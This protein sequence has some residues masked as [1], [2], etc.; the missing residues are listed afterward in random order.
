MSALKYA[1]P[2]TH[3]GLSVCL[4]VRVSRIRHCMCARPQTGVSMRAC[5]VH[6]VVRVSV[7]VCAPAQVHL[8]SF[9]RVCTSEHVFVWLSVWFVN[10]RHARQWRSLAC[11]LVFK[12]RLFECLLWNVETPL[13]VLY[14]AHTSRRE[15]EIRLSVKPV[16]Q[17]QQDVCN[18]DTLKCSVSSRDVK[19]ES[20]NQS[21]D[22]LPL[23][24]VFYVDAVVSV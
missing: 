9:Q 16:Y 7:L 12:L 20:S 1:H 14:R 22:F 15:V 11:Q 4:F 24:W 19:P 21:T 3:V 13:D 8:T 5:V 23:R 2:L 17:K 18:T 10:W 6:L